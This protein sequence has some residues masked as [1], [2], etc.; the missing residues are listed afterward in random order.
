MTNSDAAQSNLSA[1]GDSKATYNRFLLLVAGLGGLLYGVDVGIIGGALPYLEAT[2]HLNA[3]Q[4]SI[5]VAAVLL[6]SVISTLFAGL[7][8]DWMGRKPLMIVSGL[9]F[10]FSIPVIALSHGYSPLFFGRLLQGISGGL[11]GIVVPL[12]LAECLKAST[13]GK[14]TGVFQW[15]LTLGIVL[16]ALIGIYYSYRVAAVERIASPAAIFMFKNQAWRRIFWVSL[17]PGI[18]FVLGS[19]FLAESPRWLFKRG[20]KELAYAALLRSRTKEQ[21]D[22]ELTEME[23]T[24][25]TAHVQTTSAAGE[26]TKDTLLRRKYVVPFLL[27]CA[28]LLA[29]QAT[30]INSLIAYNTGILLQSGLSDVAAHWGYVVFTSVNF[31]VTIVAMTLVD[32]KGRKFLFIL[33]TS[34]IIVSMVGVG[35]LFIHTERANLDCRNAIQSMVQPDQTLTLPFDADVAKKLLAA[36]DYTGNAIQPDRAS[37]EVIYSYG[38]FTAETS[39][40]RSDEKGAAP[41]HITREGAIPN[42]KL[43]ALMKE[44]FANIEEA[45]TAPLKIQKA[46][47][48]QVPAAG[49]GW[50]VA[51]GLYMF[52]A[53]YAL[54]PGVCVWLALSELMPTRIRSNGM[55]VALV[56]NQMV[57]TILAGIFLPFVSKY[58]YSQIF[59]LFAGCT[60]LYLLIVAIFLPETKGKTLEEIEEYFEHSGRR[61]KLAS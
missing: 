29:N 52:M 55:S 3:G 45:R 28:I 47:L 44:P 21:A 6:G 27:A 32:S 13:R 57:S 53:F 24:A 59:F 11:I 49:H 19:F 14:G 61:R 60:V 39:F 7:L 43:E 48:G 34:G 15:L 5:I 51:L 18:L 46:V 20:K 12:Y 33:G 22:V 17:P 38:G 30:G 58:G 56:L 2:S 54:G 41:I 26:K 36:T 10:V 9:L 4:L 31:L 37:L 40:V 25:R 35:L 23:E 8:A 42:S 16:A 1:L 50:L